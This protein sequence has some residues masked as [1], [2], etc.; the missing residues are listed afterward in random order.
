MKKAMPWSPVSSRQFHTF[1]SPRMNLWIQ[2]SPRWF[3]TYFL[4]SKLDCMQEI[5][6][7]HLDLAWTQRDNFFHLKSP[8]GDTVSRHQ[9]TNALHFLFKNL[10]TWPFNINLRCVCVFVAMAEV[11]TTWLEIEELRMTTKLS[12]TEQRADTIKRSPATMTYLN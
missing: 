9:I 5:V 4:N 6:N 7:I 8:A 3:Q 12:H 11:A 10:S 2:L 1:M